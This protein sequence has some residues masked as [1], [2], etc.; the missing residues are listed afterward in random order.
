LDIPTLENWLWEVACVI[1]GPGDAPKFKDYILPLVFLKRLSDVF[2]DELAE[3]G[4]AARHVECDPGTVRFYL[5]PASRWA[6][7]ARKTKGLG[8]YLT[9]AARA[10]TQENPKLRGV[11]DIVDFNAAVAGQRIL[12]DEQLRALIQVLSRHRLGRQDVEPDILG[13]AYEYLI[14]KFAEGQGRS[15]GEFY[16]PGEVTILMARILDPGPGDRVYDPACGSGGLLIKCHLHFRER[17]GTN[18]QVAPLLF[19]GQETNPGTLAVARM[20]TF[21]HGMEAD[22]RSG[23]TLSRPAFLNPDGSLQRFHKVAAN[24]MWNQRVALVTSRQDSRRRFAMGY[25]P[26]FSAD[27]GWVQHMYASLTDGGKLAVMLDTGAASR[28]SGNTGSNRERDIRRQFV[29]RDLVEAVLLLPQNLF[30]NTA[31]PGIIMVI[32]RAKP[33]KG[34]V[35][36]I[37]ASRQFTKGRPKNF[38][39]DEHI[40]AT[41]DAY[42]S[43][44]QVE[45]LSRIIPTEEAARND[46][47]L[48]PSRYVTVD[49]GEEVLPLEEALVEL[50]A[51]E[52]ERR[53][54]DEELKA[55]LERLGLKR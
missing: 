9:S 47:N 1:R 54:A 25:P 32:N 8:H 35:M 6:A 36:L 51:A 45:G 4:D 17:Y 22:I 28:G 50:A 52:E 20:N 40:E 11:V 14:R 12:S 26:A 42:L 39:T 46:Y 55:V 5:P 41:A 53:Q 16:T 44:K 18:S 21:I 2:E 48:S 19:F 23:D 34:Q 27:W 24:P 31:A 29:E 37:N 10:V 3:L 38:L 49:G 43:W 33:H 13:R 7:I 30:H 15:A